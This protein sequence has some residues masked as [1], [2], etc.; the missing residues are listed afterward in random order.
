LC[1]TNVPD[2]TAKEYYMHVMLWTLSIRTHPISR[3]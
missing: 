2:A 3:H 1:Y